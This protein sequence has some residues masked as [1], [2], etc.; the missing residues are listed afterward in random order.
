MTE[1]QKL[2]KYL[3]IYKKNP[4]SKVFVF[5][6]E[7]YRNKGEIEKALRL[8]Q[9]G[10]GF[11]PNLSAGYIA[12]ALVLFDMSKWEEASQVLEKAIKISPENILAHKYLGQCYIKLKQ[13][14][15]TLSTYKM[16]L[17]LDSKNKVAQNVIKK[18]EPLIAS[19]YDETGF[20]FKSPKEIAKHLKQQATEN[21]PKKILP[22]YPLQ[23]KEDKQFKARL[24]IIETLIYKK[25]F[26]K[27]GSFIL[28]MKNLYPNQAQILKKY[29]NKYFRQKK[30]QKLTH[31][32]SHIE[33]GGSL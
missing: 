16:L 27:A 7:L 12:Q 32:L 31:L 8:C 14:L 19:Q 13:P 1:N 11:H 9:K 29:S 26:K 28:E 4:R 10:V 24:S 3:S 21:K 33:K 23:P 22:L 20:T 15:K 17:F 25:E 30:I 18:L 2:K 5:L 6:S